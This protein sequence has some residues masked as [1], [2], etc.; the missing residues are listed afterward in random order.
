MQE[1]ESANRRL[2]R[3]CRLDVTRPRLQI[4]ALLKERPRPVTIKEVHA[5]MQKGC[6]L[7][8]VYRF[9]HQLEEKG[10]VKRLEF[11]DGRSRFEWNG[12]GH[13][14]HHLICRE[15]TRIVDV[16]ECFPPGVEERIARNYG[17]GEVTHQLE[18]FG[19]CPSCR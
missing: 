1:G 15:C 8:T 12:D 16:E 6:N 3:Q 11:G 9:L 13:H 7:A 19:I 10:M 18:F 17:F 5:S 14:H 4:L 2:L